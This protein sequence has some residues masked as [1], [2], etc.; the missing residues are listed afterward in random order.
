[1][2]R[3]TMSADELRELREGWDVSQGEFAAV[4]GASRQAVVSWETEEGSDHARGVPGPVAVL[5][6]LLDKRPELRP[7]AAQIASNG[8]S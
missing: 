8:H 6:R 3:P 1:M 7:I 4:I 5:V 2:P